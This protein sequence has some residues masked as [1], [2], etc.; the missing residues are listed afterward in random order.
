MKF[1]EWHKR[2]YCVALLACTFISATPAQAQDDR[3]PLRVVASFSILA[4]MVREVG[5]DSVSVTSLVRP[6][7]DAHVFEPSPV[8][9][10][11]VAKAQLIFVNGLHFEG[12]I[13]RLI[14]ASE[15]RGPVIV[16]TR[17]IAP[18]MVGGEPDP[19]TWQSLANAKRYVENIRAALVAAR[20]ARATEI[21]RHA[22]D[23]LHRIDVL[24]QSVQQRF[25]VIPAA[26][27]RVIT[28]HDAFEYF[29]AAY[30]VEF[31]APQGWSTESEP[32]A[33]DVAR[34]VRQ[35]K[36][37]RVTALFVENIVDP[38]LLQRIG[39][40]AS[41]KLGGTL[42]SDA[43]SAPGTVADTYL[44]MMDYN[45]ATLAAALQAGLGR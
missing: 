19:H 28:S 39:R 4:D 6:D 41:V 20:P 17:G 23:Y 36:A 37:Q 42:Y 29:A 33:A 1:L 35:I 16:A 13:E 43:L 44:K 15:Y 40:E 31:F 26:Q 3:S 18:R 9:A 12:W 45:S 25:A 34:I 5:G 8:D 11:R 22:A 14:Q 7:S 10:Q 32:S 24:E 2:F 38:R 27:R 21:N 30:H